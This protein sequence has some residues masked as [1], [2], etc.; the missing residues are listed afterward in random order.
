MRG[1]LLPY[2]TA[3][4]T[5]TPLI[6]ISHAEV[7]R[8]VDPAR[9][10]EALA[11]GF[12][13][14]SSGKVQT[15]PRPMVSIPDGNFGMSML[16]W[17]PGSPIT[18][19]NV[20]VFHDN[21]TRS[22]ESH[23][24]LISLFDGGTGVPLAVLDGASITGLR[25]AACAVLSVRECARTDAR[26]ATVVGAGV[27]GRDHARLL[28]LARRFDEIRIFARNPELAA[29]AAKGVPG[30]RVVTDLEAAVR[31]SDVV[32]LTTSS[33][34]A[35]IRTDWI[36]PGTHVASVGYAPPGSELPLDLI[37]KSRV[38]VEAKSAFQPAPVGCAELSGRDASGAAELGEVL[39]GLKPG[40]TSAAEITLYK[41]MGN[42]MEDMVVA[43]LAYDEA[44]R[45]GAGQR[46][47]I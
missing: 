39:L 15:P 11:D 46:V 19:K 41:S 13:A 47:S 28:H 20:N 27:Q 31:S 33:A 42:A 9:M 38:I 23:Q 25:T 4:M 29:R 6:V 43:N 16:A 2:G 35:V 34:T 1:S 32:C 14:L 21:H 45:T 17:M 44:V 26:V 22:L 24:A 40:R 12:K 8:L 7:L 18:V 5:A 3:A 37:A 30:A 10:I 36:G